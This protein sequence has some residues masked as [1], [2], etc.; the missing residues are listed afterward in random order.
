MILTLQCHLFHHIFCFNA[1]LENGAHFVNIVGEWGSKLRLS[2]RRLWRVFSLFLVL[3]YLS[4]FKLKLSTPL[5]VI[6]QPLF[7]IFQPLFVIFQ[8]SHR[9][10]FE[11]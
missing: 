11:T 3:H 1:L 7:V 8:T 4:F 5:F 6:F 10:K 2:V 9:N